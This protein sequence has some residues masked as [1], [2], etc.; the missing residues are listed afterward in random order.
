M[1]PK[2]TTQ[3]RRAI[4]RRAV[5]KLDKSI[6]AGL[7]EMK[8]LGLL[9]YNPRRKTLLCEIRFAGNCATVERRFKVYVNGFVCPPNLLS[10]W[11]RLNELRN[12]NLAIECE[13]VKPFKGG[14]V[15]V[16]VEAGQSLLDIVSN[17]EECI[18]DYRRGGLSFD[19]KAEARASIQLVERLLVS[20]R[21]QPNYKPLADRS[22]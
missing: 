16:N 17:L 15:N 19:S 21:I 10:A 13:L 11:H 18:E 1:K 4:Q 5:A 14:F 9:P 6:K 2:L 20:A 12:E 8:T 3:S 7:N 22:V